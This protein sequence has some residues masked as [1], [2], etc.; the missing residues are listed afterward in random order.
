MTT[1]KSV[2][3]IAVPSPLYREFDYLPPVNCDRA[4]LQPGIRLRVPFGR[5]T[6]IGVL[7]DLPAQ[8][9][10]APQKLK[11]ALEILDQEPVISAEIL[12]MVQWASAYYQYPLGEALAAALPVL[13]RQGQAPVVPAITAWRVTGAGRQVDL[14]SLQRAARQRNVLAELRQHP[15]GVERGALEAPASVLRTLV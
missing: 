7:I 10:V 15:Q 5:R 9:E 1:D 2:L 11:Q 12:N 14:D 4:C 8:S 3:R 13:L 6:T